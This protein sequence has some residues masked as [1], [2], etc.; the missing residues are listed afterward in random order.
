MLVT[1]IFLYLNAMRNG[2]L[3]ENALRAK[4]EFLSNLSKEL[5]DPLRNI[6]NISNKGVLHMD[7]D[8]AECAAEVRESALKLSDMLDN[9]F[10]FSTIVA[11]A[12]AEKN[13]QDEELSKVSRYARQGIAA[14]L[15][16][17]MVV[18]FGIC[19]TTTT[20]SWGD[21][22]MQREIDTYESQL[23]G[24]IAD[25]RGTLKTFVNLLSEHPELMSDYASAVK[26]L[27]DLA[28]HYPEIFVCYMTNP[29]AEH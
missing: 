23:S 15:I 28:K 5:R 3:A 17:A 20:I 8:P 11:S 7:D 19:L 10:S 24:W 2:L 16:L 18:A 22:K 29:Y 12:P 25:Q 1:I 9:L 21:T 4:E 27:D 26:Y 13:L 14:V 6:L